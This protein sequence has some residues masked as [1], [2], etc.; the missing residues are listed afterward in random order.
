MELRSDNLLGPRDGIKLGKL[1]VCPVVRRKNFSLK[2]RTCTK[3]DAHGI[4][5]CSDVL[6]ECQGPV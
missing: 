4:T 5:H 6:G 2:Q 3:R 1:V